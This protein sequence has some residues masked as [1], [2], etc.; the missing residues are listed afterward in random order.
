MGRYGRGFSD[1]DIG[2]IWSWFDNLKRVV[3]QESEMTRDIRMLVGAGLFLERRLGAFNVGDR[4]ELA[5]TPEIGPDS[6]WRHWKERL[7]E[8][9][10]GTVMTKELVGDQFGNSY[11]HRYTVAFDRLDQYEDPKPLEK[12]CVFGFRETS[13]RKER[14]P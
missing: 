9:A 5:L 7:V 10:P 3:G 2:D 14:K 8:G 1:A 13:L 12:K 4:V 6:G 11:Y